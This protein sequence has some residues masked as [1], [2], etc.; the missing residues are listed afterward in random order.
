MLTPK[1]TT[2]KSS[3]ASLL[4]RRAE[5]LEGAA[6]IDRELADLEANASP[7]DTFT[8]RDLPPGCPSRRAFAEACRTIVGCFRS[9][10]TWHCPR[11]QWFGRRAKRTV[12]IALTKASADAPASV[13]AIIH[14][15]GFRATRKSA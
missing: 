3:R 6:R 13:D 9:G 14:D 8:S 7:A 5:L 10:H 12:A 2:V 15:A 4:R 11:D 1:T